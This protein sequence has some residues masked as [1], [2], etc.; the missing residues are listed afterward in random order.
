MNLL[1]VK[2]INAFK[3]S[4]LQ[5]KENNKTVFNFDLVAPDSVN[6]TQD[7][8]RYLTDKKYHFIR[9]C[10][11]CD[12]IR[13][14]FRGN[15]LQEFVKKI[16]AM[17]PDAHDGPRYVSVADIQTSNTPLYEHGYKISKDLNALNEHYAKCKREGAY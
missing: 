4:S 7:F 11:S 9:Y 8:E 2:S 12:P 17:S 10:I 5:A 13:C 14:G 1:S 15:R 6:A 16:L 3:W